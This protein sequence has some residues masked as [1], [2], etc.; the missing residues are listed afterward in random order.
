[1][2]ATPETTEK[3]QR[4]HASL[5]AL[6]KNDQGQIVERVSKDVPSEVADEYV[7]ALRAERMTYEHAVNL[8]PGRYTVETAVVD[9]EGNRSSTN[10]QRIDNQVQPGLALSDIALVHRV[11]NL[12][13]PPDPSDPFEIPGKRA[14]PFV[15]TILA[16][17]TEP[18]VYFVVY[19]DKSGGSNPELRAQFLMNGRVVATQKSPL[20][21]PDESGGIP[22]AIHAIAKPGGYEVR[23]KVVQGRSS[24]ERSLKYAIGAK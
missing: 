11:E 3:R 9:Q 7:P 22:M 12:S 8:A 2:T 17:G 16:A 5:L 24:I 6:I 20:P 14:S 23:V 15:S 13:R 10:V 18:F 1:L 21:E 4:F 19:P